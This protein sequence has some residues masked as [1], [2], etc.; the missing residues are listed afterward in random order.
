MKDIHF[1]GMTTMP[2]E[3]EAKDGELSLAINL[4]A[5]NGELHPRH[6]SDDLLEQYVDSDGE[7]YRLLLRHGT[8]GIY[9][10]H[11]AEQGYRYFWRGTEGAF[12]GGIHPFWHDDEGRQARAISELHD[13]VV[14]A[15]DHEMVYFLYDETDGQ[16]HHLRPRQLRYTL[17]VDQRQ[18]EQVNVS[19]AIDN[20]LKKWLTHPDQP[21]NGQATLLK[22]LFCEWK[23]GDVASGATLAL[24]HIEQAIKRAVANRNAFTHQHVTF[25]MAALRLF[26]GSHLLLSNPFALLPADGEPTLTVEGD[27]E[28]QWLRSSTCLHR[29]SARVEFAQETDSLMVSRLVQG[30]DIFLSE[31]Q[32]LLD[33]SG[34]TTIES[35]ENGMAIRMKYSWASANELERRMRALTYRHA[36]HIALADF[37]QAVGIPRCTGGEVLDTRDFRRH[38]MGV[39][40]LHRLEDRLCCGAV[41]VTPQSPLSVAVNY[42]FANQGSGGRA[43]TDQ[44]LLECICGERPDIDEQEEGLTADVVSIVYLREGDTSAK[45]VFMDKVRYPL[46]GCFSYPDRRAYAMDIHLRFTDSEGNHHYRRSITLRGTDNS[47]MTLGL[48]TGNA[49]GHATGRHALHS[50]FLQQVRNVTFS[51]DDHLWHPSADLWTRESAEEWTAVAEWA[52]QE[53]RGLHQDNLLVTSLPDNPLVFPDEGHLYVGNGTIKALTSR[54]RRY[55]GILFGQYPL[56]AFCSD[57]VWALQRGEGD[58]WRG[59]YRVSR[60]P[61][62]GGMPI[63]TDDEVVYLSDQ[64][65]MQLDGSKLTRLDEPI[66]GTPFDPS[67]LPFFDKMMSTLFGDRFSKRLW[68]PP[69]FINSRLLYNSRLRQISIIDPSQ[70]LFATCDVESGAWGLAE[71]GIDSEEPLPVVALT[72]PMSDTFHTPRRMRSVKVCGQ[73]RRRCDTESPLLCIMLWGSNDQYHWHLAGSSRYTTLQLPTGSPWRW[74]RIAIAGWMAPDERISHMNVEY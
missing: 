42:L 35:D 50:M 13:V 40:V 64:G 41:T 60:Q 15:F 27:G 1:K 57:G 18:Q 36:L 73:F 16:W 24:A 45:R 43:S 17:T 72:R 21:V 51:T 67:S 61:C 10:H 20:N 48:W 71:Y 74:H 30:V 49:G 44:R 32:T 5:H 31:P 68:Q 69:T 12:D 7:S 53:A 38:E 4:V 46:A 28:K 23:S 25:G 37:G 19:V 52:Q 11:D 39:G 26:D 2:S 59:K 55:G 66:S 54:V 6:I 56:Y 3:H 65:L 70:T 47:G 33:L 58:T 62:V 14:L 9:E 29:H 8:L 63:E 34:A 22:N